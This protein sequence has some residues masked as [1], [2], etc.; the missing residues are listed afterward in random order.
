MDV[1][2]PLRFAAA[3]RRPISRH[4]GETKP[5]VYSRA[6]RTFAFLAV[7]TLVSG[8]WAGD[9]TNAGGNPQRNGLSD[10][11]GPATGDELWS[12]GR[13]SI[14][15][16]QPV[17]SGKRVFLVRQ[18]DFVPNGVPNEAPVV[19]Q[20]LDTGAELWATHLPY[21]S[22]DWTTWVAG[23]SAGQVYASRGGN[24]GSVL[25]P[26]YAL[27]EATGATVWTSDDEVAAGPYDGVV[28]APNGDL[29]LSWHT[30][31][32]RIAAADGSTVWSVPRLC[33]VSGNCGAAL[34]EEAVYVADAAVGGHVIK[35][36][37]VATGAFEYESQVMTG[38]T[39]QNSP[40]VGPDGTI[41][42]SRT[43][44]NAVTDFFYAFDDTGAALVQK[45]LVPAGWSTSTELAVGP[46][47]SV[48]MV[49]P[50]NA[51]A[52]LD[53][54]TG[55]TLDSTMPIGGGAPRLAVDQD[56]TLFVSNGGFSDGTFRA[57]DSALDELWSVGVPNLNIGAPAL[58]EDGTMVV[59]GIGTNV[60]A[61]RS[62]GAG[63]AGGAGGGGGCGVGEGGMGGSG[64]EAA[65]GMGGGGGSGATGGGG[66][67][68][69]GG[70]GEGGGIGPGADVGG[71]T[72]EGGCGC[73]VA[74]GPRPGM[75]LWV[76]ALVALV[77]R[78]AART[79][80]RGGVPGAGER[81]AV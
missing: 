21:E 53:P 67:G 76:L 65:G 36:F 52:R 70:E 19:C 68:G 71:E 20:D 6:V 64:G 60:V 37:D 9:W 4:R 8:A 44:N 59:A 25:A 24:G 23:V 16:W 34:F 66:A 33:S 81:G 46:D 11:I 15:A 51:I 35:R 31:M 10:E 62:L 57:F 55:T 26:L 40:M 48:Y 78:R 54:A 7:T 39:L 75:A 17:T 30:T 38:F 14:I 28:F 80:M 27:D 42:L 58:G 47:G 5:A 61:Y 79:H 50:G 56:C 77:R 1:A 12:G 3:P 72:A 49:A 32:M 18:T 43:Q 74:P 22:G 69:A 41:Y 73:R 45:W 29:I 13:S 63:G 2:G